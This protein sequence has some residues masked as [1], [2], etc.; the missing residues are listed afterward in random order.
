MFKWQTWS[1]AALLT[2]LVALTGN[3]G[4]I[5]IQHLD[6][7]PCC[8]KCNCQIVCPCCKKYCI[9]ER[10]KEE[11]TK[12]CW[13]VECKPVCIPHFRWPWESC[14]GPPKCAK[15]RM[16]HV[17]KKVEWECEVCKYKWNPVCNECCNKCAHGCKH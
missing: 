1:S 17:L 15:V 6:G 9:P 4:E 8:N 5:E 11:I 12:D 7:P 10:V 13:E 14:C 16:V 3:S 2:V